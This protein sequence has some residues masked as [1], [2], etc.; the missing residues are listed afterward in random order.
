MANLGNSLESI[1]FYTL[2]DARCRAASKTSD[3]QRCELILS[4]RCNFRCPYCRRSGGPDLPLED[5]ENIVRLWGAQHLHNIRFSGG[6]PTLY[7]GLESLV[8]LAKAVGCERVAIS[9]NGS[10][11]VELY[12]RL[13]LA[14]VDDFSISLDA[15]CAADG[16]K[17]DGGAGRWQTVVETIRHLAPRAYVSV[18][19]VLVEGVNSV[20]A[21]EVID[22]AVSLGVADVRVIPAAQE[23]HD[24]V[25]IRVP[26]ETLA[27]HP[28]LAYRVG[29][30]CVGK[31]VRGIGSTDTSR[32]G[33]VLDDMV[34]NGSCHYP[35][36]IYFREG[37]QA[38]GKVGPNM[39][40][41]R[42]RWYAEHDAK[43]D[44]ICRRNCLDVC[45]AYNN[46][47]EEFHREA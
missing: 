4:S 29:N 1:G 44:P 20:K 19:C 17:L 46:K 37:G 25:S 47:Y 11:S 32:C 23:G 38:V 30:A 21:T 33:L 12:D 34:V 2:T 9:T 26:E 18:G 36:V 14:G 40:E 35:C 8:K 31:S 13:R 3:L 16:K 43:A 6:E 10:A 41:D 27:K 24:L 28:I 45:V 7:V 5:A 15:C 22:F 42:A 39:R